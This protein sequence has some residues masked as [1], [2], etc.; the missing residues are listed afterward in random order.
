MKA[1]ICIAL[2]CSQCVVAQHTTSKYL[3]D[4]DTKALYGLLQFIMPATIPLP[5]TTGT[6]YSILPM[7]V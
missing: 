6:L 4:K 7:T 2:I 3:A 5:M 1:V